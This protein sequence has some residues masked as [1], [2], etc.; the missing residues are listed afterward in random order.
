M[1]IL[2]LLLLSNSLLAGSMTAVQEE[3]DFKSKPEYEAI[4]GQLKPYG[5]YADKV[6]KAEPFYKVPETKPMTR[7]QQA[8][9]EAKARNRAILAE[10]NKAQKADVK[11][12]EMEDGPAKWRAETKSVQDQWKKEVQDQ[13]KQWRK[14]QMI[15]EGK[16]KVYKENTFVLPVKAEK[17][18]EKKVD[19]ATLPDVHIVNATFEVP[20]RDQNSR[21]TCS[22][23]SGIRAME[24]LLAQNK[25]IQ[26][27]SEQYFYWASKPN[28]Q[29]GPCTE[30]GSWITNGY[31]Y[32]KEQS[33]IDI[34]L[35]TYCS[36]K[37]DSLPLNET[38]V[39]LT[40]SCKDGVAKVEAYEE[41]RT[42]AEAIEKL[43]KDFPVVMGA[44][45]SEN[46]YK[47][48][49]LI[50]LED[51]K[52][53]NA[54]KMDSHSL[55]HSFLAVGVME[56]PKKLQVTEGA[57]CIIV[58]NSWGKGWGAGGYSCLT[59]NWLEKF[60]QPSPFVVVNK[61]SLK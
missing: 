2:F 22:A 37:T 5:E 4:M 54:G 21:P 36:Y 57:Y 35:E 59:Q 34:P 3:Y 49:G 26:D 58:V 29:N 32:S 45:L 31:R 44:K 12:P 48:S 8:V 25:N 46:F 38:Q 17:I 13:L 50:T 61:I 40:P 41:V 53:L 43:K 23:F 55:G 42:L 51:S 56:L 10:Q 6:E 28:C 30:K 24:I 1:N 20:V 52:K 39:P 16:I 9:E 7:G 14:E 47:N 33:R 27:L 11:T 19:V 60:R 15:F 18:V